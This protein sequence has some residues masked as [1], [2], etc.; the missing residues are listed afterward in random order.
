HTASNRDCSSDVC[1]SDLL[2]VCMSTRLLIVATDTYTDITP[3]GEV[4]HPG[5]IS[6]DLVTRGANAQAAIDTVFPGFGSASVALAI[7]LFTFTSQVAFYYISSSILIF[8]Y[9]E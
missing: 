5:H 7:S 3:V 6:P 4:L 2:F 9:I 1:A 8:F